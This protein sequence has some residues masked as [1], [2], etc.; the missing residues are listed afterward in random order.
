M[1]LAYLNLIQHDAK[2][3]TPEYLERMGKAWGPI[4]VVAAAAQEAGQYPR[5][6]LHRHRHEVSRPG[7]QK[8]S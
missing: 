4:R 7:S 5:P 3:L 8:R 6:D 1:S 2:D